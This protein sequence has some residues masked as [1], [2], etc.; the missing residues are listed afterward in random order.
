MLRFPKSL[1]HERYK[2]RE[3]GTSMLAPLIAA[4]EHQ[5]ID[6]CDKIDPPVMY[7]NLTKTGYFLPV[8]TR[9]RKSRFD[10]IWYYQPVSR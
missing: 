2:E 1:E 3:S 8:G 5:L 9:G 10:L 7:H 4:G 6:M